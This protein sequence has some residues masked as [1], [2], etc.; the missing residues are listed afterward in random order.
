ME[1]EKPDTNA[2]APLDIILILDRV[3]VYFAKKTQAVVRRG[4]NRSP[5]C[6]STGDCAKSPSSP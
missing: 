5:V 6:K 4:Y 1:E 2:G 3:I